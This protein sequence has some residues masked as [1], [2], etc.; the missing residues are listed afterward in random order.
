MIKNTKTINIK[1]YLIAMSFPHSQVCWLQE[2]EEVYKEISKIRCQT[3]IKETQNQNMYNLS[4]SFIVLF[5]KPP[6][7]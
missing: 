7:I 6:H 2:T 3:D 4:M 5:W 1:W